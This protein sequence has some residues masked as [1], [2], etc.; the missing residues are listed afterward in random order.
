MPGST[1]N[2]HVVAMTQIAVKCLSSKTNLNFK[3]NFKFV[4]QFEKSSYQATNKIFR[5]GL[6]NNQ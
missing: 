5:V 3:F 1:L 6:H 2:D 4:T